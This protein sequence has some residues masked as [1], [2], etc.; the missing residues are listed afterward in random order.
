MVEVKG[1]MFNG[2]EISLDMLT[3]KMAE[4]KALQGLQK[5]AKAAGL[6]TAKAVT[7]KKEKSANF[8]LLLAQW[9]PVVDSNLDVIAA[10]FTEF[11]GQ[12]SISFDCGDK[13][14]VIIRSKA[15]VKAKQ[16]ARKS[17]AVKVPTQEQIDAAEK[18]KQG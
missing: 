17:A 6:I 14:H 5:L 10:L 16:D 18:A 15:I 1:I 11:V 4:L 8:S 2:A 7:E 3:K 13:Y 9:V 12:D